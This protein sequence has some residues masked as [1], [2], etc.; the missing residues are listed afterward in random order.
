MDF[1]IFQKIL[2]RNHQPFLF[3]VCFQFYKHLSLFWA[4]AQNYA[5]NALLVLPSMR[6]LVNNK[7]SHRW[8][9]LTNRQQLCIENQFGPTQSSLL[10][11]YI[12]LDG[13]NAGLV[14]DD[15]YR[16]ELRI[17]LLDRIAKDSLIFPC[18]PLPLRVPN[19]A[20]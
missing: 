7:Q 16:E 4:H 2:I 8:P 5:I 19:P 10:L 18:Y 20:I 15:I 11:V 13:T 17:I 6:D 14:A 9:V 3:H 12:A 1:F